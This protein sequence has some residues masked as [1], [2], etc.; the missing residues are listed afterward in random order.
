MQKQISQTLKEGLHALKQGR[1]IL[2]HDSDG[3][4]NEIDMVI[5]A[6]HI[7]PGIIS[8][9][10]INAGG[11][12]CCSI[13]H[14]FAKNIGLS[15]MHDILFLSNSLDSELKSMIYGRTKYG[16]HPTFSIS[17]NHI[18]TRTGI[19]DSDRA[20]TAKKLALLSQQDLRIQ[21]NYFVSTFRTPGHL[22]L[23]IAEKG[24]L[25]NRQGHT[26]MSI[27]LMRLAGLT[28]VSV[29]CE[30]MDNET[31]AALSVTNAQSFAKTNNIPF[32]DASELLS[33]KDYFPWS[34]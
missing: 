11:L 18:D 19:T 25:Q 13:G 7:T 26:E 9:M 22:P 28:P 24:L 20:L 27:F 33:I 29:I 30:M 5:A 34:N 23:L 21:K 6:E 4:E 15:Y 10:R 32:L 1:L 2:L 17:V 3:R 12:I 31:H 16:D 8:L 14:G